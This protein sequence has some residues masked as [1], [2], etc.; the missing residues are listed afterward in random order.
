[1]AR[2]TRWPVDS[3]RHDRKA[4]WKMFSSRIFEV[5]STAGRLA[6]LCELARPW[7]E[8][9]STLALDVERT[10]A[11]DVNLAFYGIPSNPEQ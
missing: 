3:A 11:G 9:E 2:A 5:S 6:E 1:M 8:R 10:I 4:T 7:L